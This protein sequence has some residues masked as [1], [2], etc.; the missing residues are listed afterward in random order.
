MMKEQLSNFVVKK[1]AKPK[2]REEERRGTP[3]FVSEAPVGPKWR[4]WLNY[5]PTN[6]KQPKMYLIHNNTSLSY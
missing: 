1:N 2:K 4:R 6:E 5:Q 3:M